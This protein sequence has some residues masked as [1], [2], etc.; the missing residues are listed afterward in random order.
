MSINC[1]KHSNIRNLSVALGW[2]LKLQR[3]HWDSVSQPPSSYLLLP[4]PSLKAKHNGQI[5][6]ALP[7]TNSQ[8]PAQFWTLTPFGWPGPQNCSM[9]SICPVS[10]SLQTPSSSTSEA[11]S[12]TR[13]QRSGIINSPA[14]TRG[15]D[16]L[17]TLKEFPSTWSLPPNLLKFLI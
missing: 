3:K 14:S 7:P 16:L 6:K 13:W 1:W 17:L 2:Y 10:E 4:S 8:I 12:Q 9:S 15:K 11:P 5:L